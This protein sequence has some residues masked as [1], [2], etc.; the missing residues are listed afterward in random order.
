MDTEKIGKKT[1]WPQW[2]LIGVMI[3][4]VF[5]GQALWPGVE[6]VREYAMANTNALIRQNVALQAML[7]ILDPNDPDLP[8]KPEQWDVKVQMITRMEDR[9]MVMFECRLVPTPVPEVEE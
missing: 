6:A 9:V 1:D 2:L 3:F 7:G 4:S 5:F 8:G